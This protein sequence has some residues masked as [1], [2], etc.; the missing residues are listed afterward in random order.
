L[1]NIW[2]TSASTKPHF[3]I[4]GE[5][6][7]ELRKLINS[8]VNKKI[9]QILGELDFETGILSKTRFAS[10]YLN[11]TTGE[12]SE[13]QISLTSDT[14]PHIMIINQLVFLVFFEYPTKFD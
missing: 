1:I 12:K 14:F 3:K 4:K 11:Q 7:E 5:C 6:E 2:R 8:I 9:D 13:N 10:Y